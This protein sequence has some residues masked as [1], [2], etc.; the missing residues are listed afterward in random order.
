MS[1]TLF[2]YLNSEQ[3]DPKNMKSVSYCAVCESEL[4]PDAIFC[5]DCDPPLLPG[6]APEECGISF[7]QALLRI[8]VL[9]VLFVAVAF[10]KLDISFDQLLGGKQMKDELETLAVNEQPQDKDFQTVHIVIVDLANIRSKPSMEGDIITT[11]K[12]G[13]N[14]GVIEGNEHWTKV[15]VLG[16]TGW[17]AN[18]LFKSEITMP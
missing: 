9:V 17:I 3:G 13:M 12:H 14:L 5:P 4:P 8:G 7:G 6:E 11:V 15:R 16:K 1:D 10:G 2:G 18:K